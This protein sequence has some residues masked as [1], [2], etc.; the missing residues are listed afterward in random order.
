MIDEVLCRTAVMQN[1]HAIY[2]VPKHYL[3]HELYLLAIKS[4]PHVLKLIPADSRTVEYCVMALKKDH[5]MYEYIPVHLRKE[6]MIVELAKEYGV[7]KEF[8]P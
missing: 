1:A 3:T 2:K 6:K 5:S 8:Q 4:I 7:H